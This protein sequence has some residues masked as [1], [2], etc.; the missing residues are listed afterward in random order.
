MIVA[1]W[2]ANCITTYEKI[3]GQYYRMPEPEHVS[4]AI[5]LRREFP[6][7]TLKGVHKNG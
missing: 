1:W 5:M 7:E 2:K 3:D 6:D 4:A